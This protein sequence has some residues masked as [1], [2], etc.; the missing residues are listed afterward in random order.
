MEDLEARS[1]MKSKE[2]GLLIR[3]LKHWPEHEKILKVEML[4][5]N[6]RVWGEE[7]EDIVCVM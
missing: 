1:W 4:P 3:K 6:L 5:T 2:G 7:K